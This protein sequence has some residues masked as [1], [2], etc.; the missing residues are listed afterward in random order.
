MTPRASR[1]ERFT[2]L[3]WLFGLSLGLTS[4]A[5]ALPELPEWQR[6]RWIFGVEVTV[7]VRDADAA[8][9]NAAMAEA[10]DEAEQVA[11]RLFVERPGSEIDILLR[12][13]SHVWIEVSEITRNAL[14][15]AEEIAYDTNG[16]FDPTFPP[17]LTLWGVG[18]KRPPRAPRAFEIDMTLRRV[19]FTD[20]E[21][22]VEEGSQIRRLSRRTELDLGG[23]ARGTALDS[24]LGL[25]RGIG[26]PAAHMAT[27]DQH[28]VYASDGHPWTLALGE[29]VV[30]LRTGGLAVA[31][32]GEIVATIDGTA[33]HDR[34]D[35]R[36][37]RP[38]SEAR[39][40]AVR[41]ESASTAA[42][43]ADAV[44]AMGREGRA[45]VENRPVIEAG[46]ELVGGERWA[47]EGLR[48][49]WREAA[50]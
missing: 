22:E 43:Y 11:S 3:A 24:A 26:V 31:R 13:P 35:P 1:S 16:A 23:L 34:F 15:E 39:W 45:F 18:G 8:R 37:G 41:A 46:G 10:L 30:R 17:L 49:E 2:R 4:C 19:D 40:V 33:I 5:S 32:R 6:T 29:A 12:V 44:F 47:T 36:S 14:L 48:I 7:T 9:A 25:L 21:V 27:P 28:A 42:G 50:K 20:I 38:A